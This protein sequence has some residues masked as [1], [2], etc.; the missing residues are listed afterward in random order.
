[1]PIRQS[2]SG[3]IICPGKGVD[4]TES[5]GVYL[6]PVIIVITVIIG[7]LKR[8]DL[9]GSFT[10][11]AREGIESLISIAP[12]LIGLV[13][14][15]GMLE[16]SGFFELVTGWLSPVCSVLGV[17]AEVFPLGLM[18]PVSG[19]GS[20]A[21][22]SGILEKYGPDSIIGKTAS[23]MAGSTETTFYAITVYFSAAGLK[24]AGCTVPAALLADA[25]GMLIAA[26]TV[27]LIG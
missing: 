18:R 24:K 23:V 15:V 21:M 1:M 25:S 13:V 6:V 26:W 22:L 12:S 27:R 19:S 3:M 14:G 4:F 16:A 5:V 2:G 7:A 17:P 8:V 9:F 10:E 11:G 20:F